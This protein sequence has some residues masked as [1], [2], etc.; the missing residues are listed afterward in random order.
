MRQPVWI[1]S[2]LLI[3]MALLPAAAH[4]QAIA[5]MDGSA[6]NAARYSPP[7]PA[8]AGV[9]GGAA[10]ESETRECFAPPTQVAQASDGHGFNLDNLDRSVKPCDNFFNFADGGWV[11]AHPIPAAYP[12]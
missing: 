12:R 9:V 6:D 3:A 10:T 4:A 1:G 2:A 7:L 8:D 11:K 5:T